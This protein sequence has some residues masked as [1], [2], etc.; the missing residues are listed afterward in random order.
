MLIDQ[1]NNFL[2]DASIWPQSFWGHKLYSARKSFISQ[3]D[4][5]KFSFQEKD[6]Q[7]YAQI[8][9]LITVLSQDIDELRLAEALRNLSEIFTQSGKTDEKIALFAQLTD[10]FLKRARL[11]HVYQTKRE[12]LK[13]DAK[14]KKEFDQRLFAHEGVFY[15]LEYYLA[16]YKKLSEL[17]GQDEKEQFVK[18]KE[19]NLGFGNLPG[20]QADFTKDEVLEKFILLICDDTVRERLLTSY[21]A[22]KNAALTTQLDMA[23]FEKDFK[24]FIYYLLLSFKENNVDTLSSKFFQPYGKQ[25]SVPQLM[26]LFASYE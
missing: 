16:V 8:E 9:S 21:Y 22:C 19:I 25:P 23:G 6:T 26:A 10:K 1:F 7:A 12:S 15:C 11:F 24:K 13:L 14:Q 5:I 20:L 17:T 3:L 4:D 18:A 2:L